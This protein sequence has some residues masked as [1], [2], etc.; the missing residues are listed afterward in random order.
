MS[1]GRLR[2]IHSSD[3]HLER[4]PGGLVDLPERFKAALV[5]APLLAAEKV[6]NA[7]LTEQ[8]QFVVLAGDIIDVELAG[9][10]GVAFLLRQFERLAERH[11]T[12]YWAGGRV[13]RPDQWPT[14]LRLPN[15]VFRFSSGR[16]ESFVYEANGAPRARVTGISRPHAGHVNAADFWRDA[17]GL[18][19]IAVA[20]G[21]ADRESL[22]ERD[23]SYWA[24]GGNHR[25]TTLLAPPRSAQYAGTPQARRPN[26]AGACGCTLVEIDEDGAAHTRQIAT[27]VA[28][29]QTHRLAIGGAATTDSLEGVLIEHTYEL[30]RATPDRHL[31]LSWMLHGGG[32]LIAMLRHEK[33]IHDVLFRLRRH[34]EHDH[35]AVWIHSLEL[36]TESAVPP[37][38]LEQDSLLG[39]YLRALTELEGETTTA[40]LVGP[41]EELYARRHVGRH[42]ADPVDRDADEAY[43][44]SDTASQKRSL[45]L[46]YSEQERRRVLQKAAVL[47][48][49]L[50]SAEEVKP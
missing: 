16:P 7:A 49:D 21:K 28:R 45:R 2:L 38:L 26:E 29:W 35:P 9:P 24:L 31:I 33:K 48:A 12:V 3:W 42:G 18:P 44:A 13:D 25:R 30:R 36:E 10:H 6:V 43:A 27:D 20:H 23:M 40:D 14:A 39:D 47:G 17:E 4:P 1:I 32:P 5:D 37:G 19:S 11:V 41:L 22:A 34:F 50:L 15:N 46:R 8:A